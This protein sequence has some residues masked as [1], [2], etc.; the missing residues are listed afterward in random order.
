MNSCSASPIAGSPVLV[1][2]AACLGASLGGRPRLRGGSSSSGSSSGAGPSPN[3]YRLSG[4][5]ALLSASQ[6]SISAFLV[7]R[8]FRAISQGLPQLAGDVLLHP[9]L[10]IPG[11]GQKPD[12]GKHQHQQEHQQGKQLVTPGQ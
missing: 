6:E 1:A 8:S 7:D 12:R 4:V 9:A 5:L 11:P 10:L 2:G 3:R